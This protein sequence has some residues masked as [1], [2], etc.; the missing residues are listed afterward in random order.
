LWMLMLMLMLVSHPLYSVIEHLFSIVLHSVPCQYLRVCVHLS[1]SLRFSFST[2]LEL[3]INHTLPLYLPCRL[4]SHSP[5][6]SWRNSASARSSRWSATCHPRPSHS[7]FLC[8]CFQDRRSSRTTRHVRA[9]RL[10]RRSTFP[11]PRST[12]A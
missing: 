8:L 10:L 11:H 4:P 7:N 1:V 5:R 6:R 9:R 12:R 2:L 3:E